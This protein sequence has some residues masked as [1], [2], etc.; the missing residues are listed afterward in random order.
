MQAQRIRAGD[1]KTLLTEQLAQV[2]DIRDAMSFEAGHISGAQ[3]VD[4]NN[5]AEFIA[6]ADKNKPLL[7]C[8]YHGNSSQGAAQYFAEQG[9]S[10]AYSLDGGFEMWKMAFPDLCE[11]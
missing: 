6:A 11:R 7:V 4:N 1:A 2:A 10:E 9:F 8:C 5:I 3:R